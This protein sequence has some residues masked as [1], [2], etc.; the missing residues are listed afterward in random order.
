MNINELTAGT[1][2]D[3]ATEVAAWPATDGW[4]LTY[5]LRGPAALDL[6]GTTEG[7]NYRITIPAATTTNWTVGTYA[8]EARVSKAGVVNK[9]A[10]GTLTVLKNLAAALTAAYDARSTAQKILDAVESLLAGFTDVEEYAIAGRSLKRMSRVELLEA[11]QQLKAEVASEG[12]AA[13]LA[14]G[15]PNPRRLYVR[16]YRP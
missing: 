4:T 15:L 9:V 12:V 13:A 10:S 1:T 11:R 6:V 14:A 16:T 3:F 7:A 5:Y 8:W 2:L